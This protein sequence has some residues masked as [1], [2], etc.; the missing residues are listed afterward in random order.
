MTPARLALC[1][2]VLSAAFLTTARAQSLETSA[3]DSGL[4]GK[5][6]V[7][8]SAF[9]TDNNHSADNGYAAGTAVNVPLTAHLDLG[10]SFA[11]VWSDSDTA[12]D[13]FDDLSVSLTAYTRRGQFRPYARASFGYEWWTISNDPFY[14]LEAGSEYLLTSRLSVSAQVGWSEFLAEDWNGGS[15]SASARANYW[16][17]PSLA[18][19]PALGYSEGGHFTYG[20]AVAYRF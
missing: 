17:T 10:A 7:E 2:S 1:L 16:L 12:A 6:Y 19:S 9:L 20:L 4:L 14:Q 11:H 15:F 13:R 3:P 8:A 5:R 18:A